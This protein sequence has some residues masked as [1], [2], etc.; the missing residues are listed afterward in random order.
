MKC[1]V[2]N[3]TV[4]WKRDRCAFRIISMKDDF[5]FQENN[6]TYW[7][8]D[9]RLTGVTT[10]LGVLAKPQLYS[11]YARMAVES[12]WGHAVNSKVVVEI[13]GE[14]NEAVRLS[15]L[16]SGLEVAK[17]AGNKKKEA[18]GEHGTDAHALMEKWIKMCIKENAGK[19]LYPLDGKVSPIEALFK[20]AN[21]KVDHFLFSER[22]M[23]DKELFIAGTADFAYIG[24]DSKK[25]MSDFKTSSGI[26]GID[27]SLQVAA[28]RMLAEGEG[29]TPY[30]GATVVRMGKDSSF[31]VQQLNEY[32]LYKEAFLA[33][34]TL[35]RLQA[36]NKP[37]IKEKSY[38]KKS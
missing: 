20:W 25:Y 8:G 24:K 9:K 6:H 3:V 26:Y 13:D 29:D 17:S 32:V 11:W 37:E 31:E 4:Q 14:R 12:L 38:A 27:Y 1:Y 22:Q 36:H 34:L 35:Y 19:P 5:R 23:Y 30:D 2:K 18:A 15:V 10:V 21:E 28:Y 16:E 7:L 33:C